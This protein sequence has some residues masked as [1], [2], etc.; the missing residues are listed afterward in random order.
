ME[1]ISIYFSEDTEVSEYEG[2]HKGRRPD[3][4]VKINGD[5][6]NLRVYDLVR[7]Q[8]SFE[9]GCEQYGQYH[10]EPNLVLVREVSKPEIIEALIVLHGQRYF[11]EIKPIDDSD[12]SK[13]VRVY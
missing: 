4:Y 9:S 10:V 5:V 12:V 8:Q 13:L 1:N 6:F 3:V 11:E 2:V 7:L